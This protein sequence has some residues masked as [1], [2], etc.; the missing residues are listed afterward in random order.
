[1]APL[2]AW[3]SF[4]DSLLDELE[5]LDGILPPWYDPPQAAATV[6][7]EAGPGTA[8]GQP[9]SAG[10]ELLHPVDVQ[11]S[12]DEEDDKDK[13]DDKECP[14][15]PT[16]G[17][18]TPEPPILPIAVLHFAEITLLEAMD[19]CRGRAQAWFAEQQA[20]S[21]HFLAPVSLVY[22]PKQLGVSQGQTSCREARRLHVASDEIESGSNILDDETTSEHWV[23]LTDQDSPLDSDEE[24]DMEQAEPEWVIVGA[25]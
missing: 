15:S 2:P 18:S 7:G 14:P 13:D 20:Q 22:R 17:V 10:A 9:Q 25:A 23:E 1:M 5:Y 8:D 6:G 4:E 24:A 21:S 11:L 16:S 3:T 19:N 12:P